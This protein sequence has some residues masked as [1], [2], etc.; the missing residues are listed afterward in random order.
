MN[1]N[2]KGVLATITDRFSIDALR[3]ADGSAI[4]VHSGPDNFANIPARYGTPDQVTLDTGDSG[5][6]I[7]CGVVR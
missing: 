7:A 3:D 6:R 5:S 1:A 4:M 2:G